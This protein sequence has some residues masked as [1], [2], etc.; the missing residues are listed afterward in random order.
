MERISTESFIACHRVSNWM[1]NCQNLPFV[2]VKMGKRQAL[3][4]RSVIEVKN[5]EDQRMQAPNSASSSFVAS[6]Q[7]EL[8]REA[9]PN[10]HHQM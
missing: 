3:R 5:D 2:K 1:H 10:E 4:T 6:S 8:T 9:P 7:R